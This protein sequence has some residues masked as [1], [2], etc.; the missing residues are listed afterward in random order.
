MPAAETRNHAPADTPY[1]QHAAPVSAIDPDRCPRLRVVLWDLAHERRRMRRDACRAVFELVL[2]QLR[3]RQATPRRTDGQRG[4]RQA[5]AQRAMH[6][7]AELQPGQLV[8]RPGV[9]PASTQVVAQCGAAGV[10]CSEAREAVAD[11]FELR[12]R[13]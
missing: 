5:Q 1:A 9:G 6:G 13:R 7:R 10:A 12:E 4:R 3:I 8:A 11:C 2:A